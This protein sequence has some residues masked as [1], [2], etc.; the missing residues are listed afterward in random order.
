MKII[1]R[2]FYWFASVLMTA[3]ATCILSLTAEARTQAGGQTGGQVGGRYAIRGVVVEAGTEVPVYMAAVFEKD[4]GWFA[5]TDADGKFELAKLTPGVHNITFSLLGYEEKTVK[6]DVRSDINDIKIVLSLSSLALDEVVVTA[7]EGGELTSASKISKQT[8]EHVQPASLTDIMQLLPGS[9]TENPSLTSAANLSIR[10][11]G[12]NTANAAGTALIVDGASL[13]ND[14]NMQVL[15]AGTS[16]NASATNVASTAGGGVD[17]RQ[18]STD[19][20]ESV[21]V[22]RGIPSV[23]YGDLTSGAVVVKTKSGATPWEIRLKVDPKL[24]QVYLGKGLK[25]G[26]KSGVL[27]FDADYA[28]AFSDVRTQASA[29][30]RFN[31]QMGYSNTF[32]GKVTFNG[33]IRVN[34][35]NATNAADADLKLDEIQQERDYG[36]RANIN[37]KWMVNQPWLTNVE[38]L[39]AAGVGNQLSRSK[40][41][42]GSAGYTPATTQMTAGEALAFFTDPQY[43]SDV[44]IYGSPQDAQA[45][46]VA[47]QFGTYGK[48]TNKVLLGF[49]WKVQGNTGKGKVF[50]ADCPPSP[51]S[52]AAYRERSYNDIP[53]LHRYTGFIE[54]NLKFP[55]GAT[56]F[57]LQAGARFNGIS[58]KGLDT[59]NFTGIEPR[60]NGKYNIIKKNTGWRELSVRGGWGKSFKMPSMIYLYPEA[61]WCDMVSFSYNDFDANKYGIAVMTTG[62][63]ETLNKDLKVQQ[64]TNIEAGIE[65]DAGP[66][67]GSVVY[68]NEN[69]ING[70]G[71]VTNYVP[72]EYR[73]YGYTWDASGAPSAV[74][75]G[76][77]AYPEYSNGTLTAKG[78]EVPY[79]TDTTF[80]AFSTP[81]NSIVNKKWGVEFTLDVAKIKAINT[82]INISGAYMNM[83]T[84]NGS[85]TQKLY[86]GKVNNRTFPYVGLYGGSA[87][88]SNGSV[89]ERLSTN[90]RFITHIPSISM[91]VTLTAQMVFMDC[92]QYTSTWNGSSLPYYYDESGKRISGDAA[93]NDTEHTKMVSPLSIMDYSGNIIPFTQEM[94]QD[95]Q[96]RNLILNSNISSFYLKQSYPFYGMLN[97]RITK[98]IKKIATISFYA[99]NFL[100]I[101]GRVNNS[102]TGYPADKN[103]PIYFGAEVKISLKP[104]TK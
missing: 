14:A 40:V 104:K 101:K 8:I 76:S 46:I 31:F 15:S 27:N 62:K 75:L 24:T 58:A 66:V 85:V 47:N 23:V 99:N 63:Q 18:V 54:D 22:I 16:A 19:N 91:V 77:G 30:N 49:E 6:F 20:I 82:S 90:I 87:S 69:M 28:L 12:N 102:V 34:Y 71:F 38:Y 80:M 10:D 48:V 93:L 95:P 60:F 51:G 11:I 53:F 57:E 94:E 55:I 61:D 73:R 92:V 103:T 97:I 39:L 89:R 26:E 17:S 68:F 13:G 83:S 65:F 37:G 41:Y 33:K 1:R 74:S 64:S 84:S 2:I 100:N 45:R 56:S 70:Y 5:T 35:S 43:Y 79:I 72:M 32:A 96:Y 29:Y 42:Q 52:A 3:L 81:S 25:L 21:E 59:K 98:E 78:N 4:K 86:T 36:I 44:S 9:V 88:M 7:K 50:S 67:S